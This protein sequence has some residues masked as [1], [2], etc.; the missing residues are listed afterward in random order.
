[1]KKFIVACMFVGSVPILGDAHAVDGVTLFRENEEVYF[2]CETDGK[3]II[4][5][6]AAGNISPQNGYV[7][8]RFGRLG[9]VE[10]VYPDFS[11]SPEGR[12]LISD[13]AEGN[14]NFTHVKF[15]VDGCDYVIYDGFP[16]GLYVR[17]NGKEVANFVCNPASTYRLNTR[18]FRGIGT[19]N[20]VDSIDN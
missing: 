9:R 6:C 1:M 4:S 7:K 12:F 11:D 16:G 10:F 3:K 20:P 8:Y 17:K 2:S 14:A 15:R 18:A 19:V 5:L 13:I